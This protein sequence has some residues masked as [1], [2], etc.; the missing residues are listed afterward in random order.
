M[1]PEDLGV[2]HEAVFLV[3]SKVAPLNRYQLPEHQLNK[4][5]T[6]RC[7]EQMGKNPRPQPYMKNCKQQGVLK[8]REMTPRR[9]QHLLFCIKWLA[10]KTYV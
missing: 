4:D 9:G 6:S 8:M 5:N 10:L 7:V 1:R 2:C 3:T